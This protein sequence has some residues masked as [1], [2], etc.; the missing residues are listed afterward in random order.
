VY[1]AVLNMGGNIKLLSW[2]N[3]SLQVWAKSSLLKVERRYACKHGCNPIT[4]VVGHEVHLHTD[5]P[6]SQPP[7]PMCCYTIL[8]P[9]GVSNIGGKSGVSGRTHL[10]PG[11][12]GGE[13][14]DVGDFQHFGLFFWLKGI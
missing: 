5:W 3:W 8:K 14:D 10:L 2:W 7:H 9:E 6:F 4:L 1:S 11:D 12:W 13:K